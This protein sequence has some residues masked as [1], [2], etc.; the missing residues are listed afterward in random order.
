MSADPTPVER[1]AEDTE[2]VALDAE[3]GA[4]RPTTADDTHGLSRPDVTDDG[5]TRTDTDDGPVHDTDDVATPTDTDDVATPTD[6]DDGPTRADVTDGATQAGVTGGLARTGEPDGVASL[7]DDR[8]HE[9]LVPEPLG[10]QTRWDAIQAGF[11]DEPR[12]SVAEADALVAEVI[13]DITAAFAAARAD[14]EAQWSEG[15]EA[16]TE[17]LRQAFRRYRSFFQRLLAT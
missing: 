5:T 9:A 6:T 3:T 10:Y 14:L 8:S 13:D 4:E 15:G 1:P 11:V 7:D 16:S 17:D 12:R 2:R